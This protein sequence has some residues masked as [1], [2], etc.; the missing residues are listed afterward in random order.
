MKNINAFKEAKLAKSMVVI[1]AFLLV[2]NT[3]FPGLALAAT[4]VSLSTDKANIDRGTTVSL[5][6]ASGNASYCRAPWTGNVSTAGTQVMTVNDTTTFSIT[7]TGETGSNSASVTVI[8][9]QTSTGTSGT[10]TG[11]SGGTILYGL[12]SVTL[13]SNPIS[14][15]APGNVVLSWNSY[16]S[17]NCSASWTGSRET[18]GN[19]TVFVSQTTSFNMICSGPAGSNSATITVLVGT[20][21]TSTVPATAPTVATVVTGAGLNVGVGL[22]ASPATITRGGAVNL[23]WASVNADKCSAPWTLNTAPSGRETIY[24]Q[25][26][27]SYPITCFRD[28]KTATVNKTV[29]VSG[30]SVTTGGG[31]KAPSVKQPAVIGTVVL[32]ASPSIIKEGEFTLL[33]WNSTNIDKCNAISPDNWTLSTAKVGE[34]SVNPKV[35][36]TYV[37]KCSGEKFSDFANAT[38]VVE[39]QAVDGDDDKA[40]LLGSLKITRLFFA[41]LVFIVVLAIALTLLRRRL[42]QG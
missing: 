9:N 12:P 10:S 39:S 17:T 33:R 8:V 13:T 2:F 20:T 15:T 6:W 41:V 40:T 42:P 21:T 16:N 29:V 26:T 4:S 37:I 31:T 35:T 32:V 3:V 25:V 7:C 30:A 5:S 28:G 23:F 36:T 14:L 22:V 1:I 27:T 34:Q 24:P 11:T 19:Q 18:F 38:V